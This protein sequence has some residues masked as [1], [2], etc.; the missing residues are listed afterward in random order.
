MLESIISKLGR[1]LAL[2][3]SIAVTAIIS[4]T[5]G[6]AALAEYGIFLGY[7]SLLGIFVTGGVGQTMLAE[8]SNDET[9]EAVHYASVIC[10]I[11]SFIVLVCYGLVHLIFDLKSFYLIVVL[12]AIVQAFIVIYKTAQV[13][14]NKI[15]VFYIVD[16]LTYVGLVFIILIFS[17]FNFKSVALLVFIAYLLVFLGLISTFPKCFKYKLVYA[18]L[19]G[20]MRKGG[21]AMISVAATYCCLKFNTII[22]ADYFNFDIILISYLVLSMIIVDGVTLFITSFLFADI[23]KIKNKEVTFLSCYFKY[24]AVAVIFTILVY[25][26]GV[27]IVIYIYDVSLPEYFRKISEVLMWSIPPLVV[28]KVVSYFFLLD[29]AYLLYM[30]NGLFFLTLLIVLNIIFT[31]S[32]ENMALL[33]VIA[34]SVTALVMGVVYAVR[35]Q[36]Y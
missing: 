33:F 2:L 30:F 19:L 29:K 6:E 3:L 27:D 9:S 22:A 34:S 5:M 15:H 20:I 21:G 17:Y 14:N 11:T 8:F 1:P 18:N 4:R 25:F 31:Q 24:A 7:V 13:L 36:K 16:F 12:V 26:I 23:N 35:E 10:L 32:V 28:L